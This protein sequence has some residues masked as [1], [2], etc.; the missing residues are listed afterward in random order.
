MDSTQER[1]APDRIQAIYERLEE[2]GLI[3]ERHAARCMSAYHDAKEQVRRR[4]AEA[5]PTSPNQSPP[6][7]G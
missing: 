3:G 1:F 2:R 4:R 6:S 7:D 5:E